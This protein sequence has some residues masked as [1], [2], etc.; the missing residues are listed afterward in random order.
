MGEGVDRKSF[1][2]QVSSFGREARLRS[3]KF[4]IAGNVPS[5]RGFHKCIVPG[6]SPKEGA[7]PGHPAPGI[8]R[9]VIRGSSAITYGRD[10][11]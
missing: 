2:F 7:N 3:S 11:R 8:N 10:G 5:V 6:L 9:M 4:N 1:E